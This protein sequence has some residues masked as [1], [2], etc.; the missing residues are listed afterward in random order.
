M[1]FINNLYNSYLP[2][3]VNPDQC[4]GIIVIA[5]P[6][7]QASF[8]YAN[9]MDTLDLD[10]DPTL[11]GLTSTSRPQDMDDT[12][13][14]NG[15]AGANSNDL[16]ENHT[17]TQS[18]NVTSDSSQNLWMRRKVKELGGDPSQ[19]VD[20][21]MGLNI[22]NGSGPVEEGVLSATGSR[23]FRFSSEE[24]LSAASS[25]S[26]L[27]SN[28]LA[29]FS[30]MP[31]MHLSSSVPPSASTNFTFPA[32]PSVSSSLSSSPSVNVNTNIATYNMPFA[33][34][35]LDDLSAA[36]ISQQRGA[37]TAEL[38]AAQ[39][40][41][42]ASGPGMTRGQTTNTAPNGVAPHG[43]DFGLDKVNQQSIPST[44]FAAQTFPYTQSSTPA[45]QSHSQQ[46]SVS[47]AS[48][49]NSGT[50]TS[51]AINSST[52]PKDI[53]QL[54]SSGNSSSSLPN[55]AP[56]AP[57]N[58]NTNTN[59]ANPH[60]TTTFWNPAFSGTGKALTP[61]S[62]I[63]QQV[64]ASTAFQ[65]QQLQQLQLQLMASMGVQHPSQMN[66]QQQQQLYATLTQFQQQ[67]QQQQHPQNIV[68]PVNYQFPNQQQ[69]PII[70]GPQKQ[71]LTPQGI[72]MAGMN[73]MGISMNMNMI[74]GM[75]TVV[76][77]NMNAL[78]G[79]NAINMNQFY[80]TGG[81]AQGMNAGAGTAITTD[82]TGFQTTA[83]SSVPFGALAAG[84]AG[85][86]MTAGSAAG[87]VAGGMRGVSA[88]RKGGRYGSVPTTGGSNSAGSSG[89]SGR[90]NNHTGHVCTECRV[91]ES[92]EWR[93]GPK[94]PKTLCNA[95]G[96]R[97]AKKSRKENQK[98]AAAAAA[99]A[100]A[101]SLGGTVNGTSSETNLAQRD[102]VNV[103]KSDNDTKEG[104][105]AMLESSA[106]AGVGIY[107][108]NRGNSV[109]SLSS[110]SSSD[111]R[112]SEELIIPNPKG[113]NDSEKRHHSHHGAHNYHNGAGHGAHGGLGG[114]HH[115]LGARQ[116]KVGATLSSHKGDFS[117]SKNKSLGSFSTAA[118]PAS[119]VVGA[120]GN[121]MSSTANNN[122]NNS[123]GNGNFGVHTSSVNSSMT[124][125]STM[126]GG[127]NGNGDQ[128]RVEMNG[129]GNHIINVNQNGMVPSTML[130]SGGLYK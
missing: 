69:I 92:P 114:V 97:W 18:M 76:P 123:N 44:Y 48:S 11:T 124:N 21:N 121:G 96:L 47:S 35:S 117:V 63:Q 1:S 23:D 101:S 83:T 50:T 65:Q 57:A 53:N 15:N 16:E 22:A 73:V 91:E 75:N 45:N 90:G 40:V 105:D 27:H 68:Q 39:A 103:L 61:G 87:T 98:A 126:N 70:P 43:F 38:A 26:S 79:I 109:S 36:P 108:K 12:M 55:S 24:P 115:G 7:L 31:N 100:A 46:S 56:I 125:L 33:T 86:T 81:A 4:K 77:M 2:Q 6:N 113:R 9:H 5:T 32:Y 93:K 78:A 116:A 19:Y 67:Q 94:G 58:A 88:K 128:Q 10:Q 62:D 29:G 52:S 118:I 102:G 82:A 122:V 95:C 42:V 8:K 89:R 71:I 60:T 59:P 30:P 119:A 74:P 64:S 34:G 99:A 41:A 120:S 17:Q 85:I 129:N 110:L 37:T 106:A 112:A 84:H 3:D 127:A 49:C 80:G 13:I 14:L 28:H 111:S 25:T 20:M 66:Q 72:P 51:N 104:I 107:G 130:V 54:S